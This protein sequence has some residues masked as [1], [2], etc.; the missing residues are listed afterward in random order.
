MLSIIIPAHDEERL[1][2]GT[3]RALQEACAAVQAQYQEEFEFIVVDDASSDGTA[4]AAAALGARVERVALRRISSVRNAGARVAQGENL[5]FVDADTLVPP[6]TLLA[7]VAALRGGAVGGGAAIRFD[8]PIPLYARMLTPLAALTYRLAGIASGCFT[9]CRREAFQ[10]V[11]GYNERL[12]AGEEAALSKALK[13]EGRLAILREPV[14][15]SG[16]KLRAYSA[17]EILSLMAR[18]ALRPRRTAQDPSRW[19]I[20]Y[21]PRR[22]D[23]AAPGI[24]NANRM[25]GTGMKTH[26]AQTRAHMRV[27]RPTAHLEAV[28]TMYEE[29]LSLER[30]GAFHDHEGFD[31]VMLGVP[32]A[33]YHLEFTHER[34]Q[35]A[36]SAPST[37]DLLVFYLPDQ[38]EW[39]AACARMQVAGFEPVAA[40]NPYWEERG[41]TFADPDGYRVVL[42]RGAWPPQE[43]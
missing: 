32:G 38:E 29:G 18:L 31:G 37:E 9:F 22:A 3:L 24:T 12:V 4:A 8:R 5:V 10:A 6:A 17:G 7:A 13:R 41:R 39:E 11:G 14:V 1:I 35:N 36:G 30:L 20:L 16:R 19:G 27:A 34:G 43:R 21:G 33:D 15:T 23:P 42:Q 2:G 40:H 26:A 25:A 28:A